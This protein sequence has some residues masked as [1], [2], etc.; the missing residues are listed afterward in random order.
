M[1][2]CRVFGGSEYAA[3]PIGR[4]EASS[5]LSEYEVPYARCRSYLTGVP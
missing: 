5:F 2:I 3:A 1:P 4:Y